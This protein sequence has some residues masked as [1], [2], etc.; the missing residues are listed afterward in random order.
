MLSSWGQ[1][2]HRRLCSKSLSKKRQRKWLFD[3]WNS[4]HLPLKW[5]P[6][7]F[8]FSPKFESILRTFPL[9]RRYTNKTSTQIHV[10]VLASQYEFK[11][12]CVLLFFYR[13]G[14]RGICALLPILGLTW[15]FGVL[16]IGEASVVF[17]YLFAIF[18][19]LQVKNENRQHKNYSKLFSI[20][21]ILLW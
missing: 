5:M 17:Q 19:S 15:V 6:N 12:Q 2:F 13:S 16:S 20:Q 4:K 18:N 1:C 10:S 9:T 7:S 8:N 11:I 14:L 3:I 21:T